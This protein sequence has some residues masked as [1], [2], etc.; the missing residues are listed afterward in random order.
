[1]KQMEHP[2]KSPH[3]PQSLA[4]LDENDAQCKPGERFHMDMGFV[5]GTKYSTKD[6]DGRTITQ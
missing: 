4:S 2:T 6:E 1:M 5:R 3:A